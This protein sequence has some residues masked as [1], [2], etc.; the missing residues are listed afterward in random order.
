[1]VT[2]DVENECADAAVLQNDLLPVAFDVVE[3]DW[4]FG[5]SCTAGFAG[6]K[7]SSWSWAQYPQKNKEGNGNQYD[8]SWTHD[9][10][11]A[12]DK[13]HTLT[14]PPCVFMYVWPEIG[15]AHV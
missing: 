11:P 13:V 4:F 6:F 5:V 12:E 8:V 1:M 3:G 7:T 2:S 15:R 10:E 9:E 14:Q